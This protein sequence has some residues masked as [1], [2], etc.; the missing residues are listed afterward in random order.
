MQYAPKLNYLSVVG[1]G[2]SARPSDVYEALKRYAQVAEG[3][4]YNQFPL[5]QRAIARYAAS[6]VEK[7]FVIIARRAR[8]HKA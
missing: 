3:D 6:K 4:P 8:L 7:F 5:S 2:L 1:E